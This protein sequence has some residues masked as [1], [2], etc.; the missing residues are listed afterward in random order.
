ML[1][2]I[3]L[4]SPPHKSTPVIIDRGSFPIF[5]IVNFLKKREVNTIWG[6]GVPPDYVWNM[7]YHV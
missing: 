5:G 4:F 6:Y 2:F 3:G 1:S 7:L